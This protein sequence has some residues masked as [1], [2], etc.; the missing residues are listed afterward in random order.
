MP[1]PCTCHLPQS[2][3]LVCIGVD[4]LRHAEALQCRGADI[5]VS[6]ITELGGRQ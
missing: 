1:E 6:S 2:T 3:A 4:R 5:V